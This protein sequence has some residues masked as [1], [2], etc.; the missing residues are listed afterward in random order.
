MILS[1]HCPR[2]FVHGLGDGRGELQDADPFVDASGREASH[3]SNGA[4]RMHVE[5]ERERCATSR[6]AR[7]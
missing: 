4:V 3:A 6:A 7:K 2:D 1:F 5:R